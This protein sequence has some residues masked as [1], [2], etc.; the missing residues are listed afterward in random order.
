MLAFGAARGHAEGLGC[1]LPAAAG[2]CERCTVQNPLTAHLLLSVPCC[3]FHHVGFEKKDKE[4]CQACL[5]P[6]WLDSLGNVSVLLP[7]ALQPLSMQ[8]LTMCNY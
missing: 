1:P 7:L 2:Y 3:F 5:L 6:S 8:D 4:G